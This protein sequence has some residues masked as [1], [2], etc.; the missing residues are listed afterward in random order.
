MALISHQLK[1]IN[2][3]SKQV[4]HVGKMKRLSFLNLNLLKV[5]IIM[6][7]TSLGGSNA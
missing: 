1:R 5:L 7:L 4:I 2:I 3:T 6:S